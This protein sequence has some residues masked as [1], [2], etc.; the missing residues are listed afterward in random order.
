ME[1]DVLRL[2]FMTCHPVLST[3]ARVA[4]TLRLL[5][6]LSTPEI[7]RAFLVSE[8]T[9]AQRIVRAKRTLAE[10]R[11]PFEVPGRD[12]LG[13]RLPAVLEVVYL[14][15]NEG[16]AATAGEQLDPLDAVRGRPAPRPHP[17]RADAARARGPR[18]ARADGA[19]GVAA[20]GARRAAR[21]AGA[22][23]RPG[24][25]PLGPPAGP[26]RSRRARAGHGAQRRAR[27]RTR[28]RRPSPRATR[29][30]GASRRPTGRGSSRC[31]TASPPSPAPRSSSSTAPWR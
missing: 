28:S 26:A 24:P 27:A 11:V 22:A 18:P 3:E 29:G 25:R 20:A 8:A 2:V 19:A 21:R 30:P 17:R 23:G 13:D 7:A 16:Y 9:V 10:A 12:E 14:V 15:F 5:G 1:D 4:L 31:T 6:G